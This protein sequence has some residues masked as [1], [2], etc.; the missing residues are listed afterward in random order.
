VIKQL[1]E[2]NKT[3]REEVAGKATLRG[4]DADDYDDKNADRQAIE[5]V[6]AADRSGVMGAFFNAKSKAKSGKSAKST[7]SGAENSAALGDNDEI[8][9]GGGRGGKSGGKKTRKASKNKSRA[10]TTTTGD[11]DDYED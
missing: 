3:K 1:R 6:G 8:E 11:E 9:L 5:D 4:G 10:G 7:R 2:K